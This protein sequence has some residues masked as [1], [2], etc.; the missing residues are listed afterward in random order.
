MSPFSSQF[1]QSL[2]ATYEIT[3]KAKNSSKIKRFKQLAKTISNVTLLS[4][5]LRPVEARNASTNASTGGASNAGV[6]HEYPHV[7]L[8]DSSNWNRSHRRISTSEADQIFAVTSQIKVITETTIRQLAQLELDA[9][10]YRLATEPSRSQQQ[11]L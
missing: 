6:R 1:A 7:R 5:A 11:Q 3:L 10:S 8:A 9:L 4:G 2:Y